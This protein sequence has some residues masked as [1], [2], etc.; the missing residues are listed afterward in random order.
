MERYILVEYI[1]KSNNTVNYIILLLLKYN[2]IMEIFK[3]YL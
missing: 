2:E 1:I 3:I